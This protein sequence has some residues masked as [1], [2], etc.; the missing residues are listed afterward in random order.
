MEGGDGFL[1][2]IHYR[3]EEGAKITGLLYVDGIAHIEGAVIGAA[4]LKE[5]YFYLGE[6]LYS[7]LIYNAKFSRNDNVTYPFLFKD[8]KFNRHLIK[9]IE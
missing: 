2:D 1:V 5:C 6:N 3:Q 4:Y 9:K 8:S 7:G